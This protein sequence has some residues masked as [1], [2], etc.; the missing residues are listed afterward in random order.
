[1]KFGDKLLEI[2]KNPDE[3]NY[4]LGVLGFSISLNDYA[5]FGNAQRLVELNN[6]VYDSKNLQCPYCKQRYK[7]SGMIRHMR[8]Q[9]SEIMQE[10]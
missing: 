3:T 8:Y 7:P 1:M 6:E 10:I 5:D 9:H 4:I 2:P